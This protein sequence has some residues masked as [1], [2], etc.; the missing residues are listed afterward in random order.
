LPHGNSK[1][2]RSMEGNR[3]KINK[4]EL[5]LSLPPEFSEDL[6]PNIHALVKKS[7]TKIIVLDDDP[8]G[9]QTV[10]DVP[11]LTEWSITS[12]ANLLAET[13]T[14]AY[15][16][17]N[18][19]SVS[20][21]E[22]QAINRDIAA[23]L[24]TAGR[25]TGRNFVVISRS[26]STLRGHYPGEVIALVDALDQQI[27]GILII[28]FFLEGGRLTVHDIH[29]VAEGEWLVP[30]AETE[31]ARDASF[32]YKH[33]NLRE[34]VV[35][36][37]EGQIPLQE[38]A[39]IS[40]DDIRVGGVKKVGE[41]LMQLRNRRVCVVNSVTYRDLEVFVSGLLQAE[42]MGRRFVYRTASSFVRVRGGL[43]DRG[44]LKGD[45]IV[46]TR[47]QGGLIIAGS[48]I[49]KST[50]Q[51]EAVQALPNVISLEVEVGK[52]LDSSQRIDEIGRVV[53]QAN[54]GMAAGQDAL[55]YTSRKLIT[56][57]DASSSLQIG[58]V[59]S[60]ALVQIVQ[61][62]HKKPAWI[63]AKGGI[64]SSDVAT[65]GLGVRRAQV[66][67]QAI[68]GVPVWQTGPESRWPG[69]VYVVFPGNVGG[70]DAIAA[71]VKI[72]RSAD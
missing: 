68:A 22:A 8:T 26:D 14:I 47:Q 7:G 10:Y 58:Q 38:V 9:T 18:S 30:A 3:M 21:G 35:E 49:Q 6:L 32:G 50:L 55:V 39:S 16:L 19:R 56:G 29:Y 54:E 44:L 45:D 40:L 17:T 24:K 34:W 33:S 69:L 60:A 63:I 72:L 43:P 66:L 28:P 25:S 13:G 53:K 48:Y 2:K 5:L 65:K 1:I 11:V 70:P 23:N 57:Q 36:K 42:G 59:I 27:D 15:I 67:G 51:I 46:K 12:L 37:N 31:Y 62:I 4:N 71:M 64:T 52:L 41:C 20:L 61:G